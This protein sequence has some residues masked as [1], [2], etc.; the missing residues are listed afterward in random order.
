[1]AKYNS[2]E[3]MKVYQ[4]AVTFALEIYKLS[5]ENTSLLK[6]FGIKDQLKIAALYIYKNI[7]EGF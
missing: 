2:F 5:Q 6:D 1:M 7:A 4:Q 3:E